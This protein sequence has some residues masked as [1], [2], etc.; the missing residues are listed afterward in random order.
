LGRR[1]RL[2][3][4]AQLERMVR[5]DALDLGS[6]VSDLRAPVGLGIGRGPSVAAQATLKVDS[7][8]SEPREPGSDLAIGHA[9]ILAIRRVGNELMRA[10]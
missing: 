6:P 8:P 10:P 2:L 7:E 9:H 3:E 4:G 1:D 5:E